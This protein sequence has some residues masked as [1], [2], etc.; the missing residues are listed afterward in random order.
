[1]RTHSIKAMALVLA[2]AATSAP[3]GTLPAREVADMLYALALANRTVYTR[4]VVQRLG[5]TGESVVPATE[6]YLDAR[7]LPLPARMFSLVAEEVDHTGYWL[8]LRSL[9][10]INFE[11]GP[12][13]PL[14]EQGLA[15]VRANP[16]QAFY[17]EDDA[18]G[19]PSLVAVYADVAS[20]GA[21]VACHNAHP[22]SPRRD[23]TLG[24][25]MGGVIVRVFLPHA[26]SD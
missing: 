14:E 5:P 12:L 13:T 6:H 21:C 19:A 2:L 24:D 26:D 4:D 10:P 17:A 3:A 20:V 15:F 16:G 11:N 8:S 7:A 25:V 1:M 23:F 18:A 9:D 22:R